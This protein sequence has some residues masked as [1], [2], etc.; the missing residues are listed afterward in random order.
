MPK[1]GDT[2]RLRDL[3][4][5]IIRLVVGF[6]VAAFHGYGKLTGG[7]ERWEGIG[8]S[9]SNLGITFFPVFWGFMAMFAEFFGAILIMLGLFTRPAAALLACTMLV[10]MIRHLTLPADAPNA[11]WSGASHAMELFA[12]AIGLMLTGPGR[13]S[14]SGRFR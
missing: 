13:F 4:L 3:G 11:G 5:L 8:G 14:I 12:V 1:L 7:S 9:M 6:S 2:G 10:A